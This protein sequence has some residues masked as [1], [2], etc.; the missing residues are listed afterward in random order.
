[1]Y[2]ARCVNHQVEVSDST[3]GRVVRNFLLID[4]GD[5]SR[6]R[7]D[8]AEICIPGGNHT[9]TIYDIESGQALRTMMD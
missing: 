8:G 4:D 6:V 3:S 1:M 9:L 2:V 7:V 5:M